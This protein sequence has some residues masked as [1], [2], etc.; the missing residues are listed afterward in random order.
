MCRL[1][2]LIPVFQG[3]YHSCIV[4]LK[5]VFQFQQICSIRY[6]NAI[7]HQLILFGKP[8]IVWQKVTG[9]I[10]MQKHFASSYEKSGRYLFTFAF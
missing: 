1:I 4:Q 6:F 2:Q 3:V 5:S 8:S 10:R 7:K 9:K